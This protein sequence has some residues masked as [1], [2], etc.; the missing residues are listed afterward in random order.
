MHK[1]YLPFF[2][3]ALPLRILYLAEI[4]LYVGSKA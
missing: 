2:T 1:K 3:E 4:A